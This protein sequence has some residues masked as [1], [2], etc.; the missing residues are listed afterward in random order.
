MYHCGC[1]RSIAPLFDRIAYLE[2]EKL[3][4]PVFSPLA[5]TRFQVTENM[6]VFK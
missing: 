3:F 5:P 1:N 2:L 4:V 6:E